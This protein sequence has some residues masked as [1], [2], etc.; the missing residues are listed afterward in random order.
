MIDAPPQDVIEVSVFSRGY[1]ESIAI[2]VGGGR[3]I[4]VDCLKSAARTPAAA[5]YLDSINVP[6]ETA[7][8][9]VLL[10]HWHDDHVSGGA[11]LVKRC[12]NATIVLSGALLKDEFSQ[13]LRRS[14]VGSTG[15][16]GTGIDEMLNIL[17]IASAQGR[18]PKWAWSDRSL[19]TGRHTPVYRF[20]ALSPSDADF[21]MLLENIVTWQQ[22]SGRIA[23]PLR[24]HASVAAVIEAS[25]EQ[26]LLGADLEVTGQ[27]TGWR[28]VH[29]TVWGD[30]APAS[31]FKIAHH[32]AASG[33]HPPVWADMIAKNAVAVLTPWSRGSKL[34]TKEDVER[35]LANTTN[36]YA[37][38]KIRQKS[39]SKRSNTVERSLREANIKLTN[40]P[41]QMGHIRFR[42]SAGSAWQVNHISGSSCRLNEVFDA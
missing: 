34:P 9:C 39:S 4:I 11:D 27:H 12:Q 7:V 6:C 5:D 25:G 35:I 42:K 1:G 3:W 16:F 32:G 36:A 31:L 41:A 18:Q 10:T 30:R 15:S 26:I 8:E 29:S 38:S 24:N 20:D 13:F 22:N 14:K 33:D 23:K 21:E 17:R 28:N 40:E 19:S 2:H 37:A